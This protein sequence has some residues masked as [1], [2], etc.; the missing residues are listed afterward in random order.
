MAN[1]GII[2]R[3]PR[4][5]VGDDSGVTHRLWE[6]A[7]RGELETIQAHIARGPI[8]IADGHHRYETALAHRR[9]R[10][11][12]D[13]DPAGDQP[14]DFV[15]TVCV[16]FE[17]P[18]L[19]VLPTH[20]IVKNMKGPTSAALRERLGALFDLEIVP[21]GLEHLLERMR[22]EASRPPIGMYDGKE[23]HLLLPRRPESDPGLSAVSPRQRRLNTA[24]LQ[25][26]ILGPH[27]GIVSKEKMD[28]TPDA[29]DAA[30]RIDEGRG[31]LAFFLNA[32]PMDQLRDIAL[33]R[34][35]MP[36]KTT[37]FTPKLPT[38][39]VFHLFD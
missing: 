12:K 38:G 39:M 26:L 6:I 1:E 16:A 5:T 20:R 27:L 8:H 22:E 35:V 37:Y 9:E 10:R 31:K 21:G 34:E 28:Y 33:A 18:G 25:H 32:V 13:G 17:D 11:E 36:P 23:F 4:F 14:Y 3:P 30:R 2:T 29:A 7:G 15:M 24:V 19:L